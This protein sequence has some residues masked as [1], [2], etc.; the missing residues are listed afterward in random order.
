MVC[1]AEKFLRIEMRWAGGGTL[2][3]SNPEKSAA[4]KV[5]DARE[6]ADK[7]STGCPLLELTYSNRTEALLDLLTSRVLAERAA[8]RGPWEL[9]ARADM[10]PVRDYLGTESDQLKR[11]QLASELAKLFEEYQLS[12]PDW[13]DAWRQGKLGGATDPGLETWQARLW[14]E[15]VRLLGALAPI[16]R[17][18]LLGDAH[19]LP[20][21]DEGCAFRDMVATL[22]GAVPALRPV[23]HPLRLAG[24]RPAARGPGD[25]PVLPPAHAPAHRRRPARGSRC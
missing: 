18:V 24:R 10:K 2:T 25:Q 12:R 22:G 4:F 11:V 17:L 3:E 21:V 9:L 19:Q 20:S 16:A 1:G 6:M 7:P 5:L 23:P 13:V 8:G 15:A 14:L